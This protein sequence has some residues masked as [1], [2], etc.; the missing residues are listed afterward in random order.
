MSLQPAEKNF[1]IWKGAT[2]RTRLQ[3]LTGDTGSPAQDLTGYTADCKITD[4]LNP[5]ITLL[6][7]TDVNA[8]IILG[9]TAGTID[10][11]IDEAVTAALTWKGGR[12]QLFITSPAGDTDILLYGAFKVRG[13]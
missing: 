9:G 13:Y 12:Y 2:F 10:I 11:V 7:L 5:A 6:E 8:G 3:L 4:P 1:T